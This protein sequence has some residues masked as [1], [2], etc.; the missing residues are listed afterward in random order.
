MTDF[1]KYVEYGTATDV[2][3]PELLDIWIAE[4]IIRLIFRIYK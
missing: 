3:P 1:S 4:Q 2:P